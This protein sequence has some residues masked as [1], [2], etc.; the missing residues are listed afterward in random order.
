MRLSWLYL[1]FNA[2]SQLS[3][4]I[5]NLG[6]GSEYFQD[7]L[8]KSVKEKFHFIVKNSKILEYLTLDS[9]VLDTGISSKVSVASST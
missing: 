3:N 9:P 1:R 7:L 5:L 2:N 4:C 8:H 6:V